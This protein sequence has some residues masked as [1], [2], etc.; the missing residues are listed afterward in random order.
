MT[1]LPGHPTV[2][3]G[4]ATPED[5]HPG[6]WDRGLDKLLLLGV[7]AGDAVSFWIALQAFNASAAAWQLAIFVAAMTS[8]AIVTMHKAG[9]YARASKARRAAHG[10]LLVITLVS[11]WLL[12]GSAAFVVRVNVTD[13]TPSEGLFG[14]GAPVPESHNLVMAGLMLALFLAGGIVAYAIGFTSYNPRRDA[15]SRLQARLGRLDRRRRRRARRLSKRRE[16]LSRRAGE[17]DSRIAAAQRALDRDRAVLD[18]QASQL[19]QIARIRMAQQLSLP[20]RT[21]GIFT[22]R[23]SR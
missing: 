13:G 7:A 15:V 17:L 9:S 18:A 23:G 19:R 20:S 21:T 2:A 14:A 16:A 1:A 12:L 22:E 8:A 3:V 5:D 10:R 6:R 4:F 11:A